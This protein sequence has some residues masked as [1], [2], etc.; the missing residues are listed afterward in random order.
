MWEDVT[1]TLLEPVASSHGENKIPPSYA[2][3]RSPAITFKMWEEGTLL[4]LLE[5]SEGEEV[6]CSPSAPS[7]KAFEDQLANFL[8]GVSRWQ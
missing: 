3:E 8:M 6:F 7:D 2:F 1:R 5:D 4:E